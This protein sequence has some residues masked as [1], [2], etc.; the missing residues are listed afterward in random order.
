MSNVVAATV[1]RSTPE[2]GKALII[3]KFRLKHVVTLVKELKGKLLLIT[4]NMKPL[5]LVL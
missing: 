1:L 4:S 2:S 3:I 5:E